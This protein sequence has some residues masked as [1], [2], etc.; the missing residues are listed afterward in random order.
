LTREFPF[1]ESLQKLINLNLTERISAAGQQTAQKMLEG[2]SYDLTHL[3]LDGAA[4]LLILFGVSFG[5]SLLFMLLGFIMERGMLGWANRL[6]G[7]LFSLAS[8]GLVLALIFGLLA[9]IWPVITYVGEGKNTEL[10]TAIR[11]SLETS[12]L[13]PILVNIYGLLSAWLPGSA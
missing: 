5:V 4:F 7:G 10:L 1:S 9:P 12:Q 13:V 6:L 2:L 11:A 8:Q 3:I